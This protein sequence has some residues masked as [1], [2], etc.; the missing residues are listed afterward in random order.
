MLSIYYFNQSI[1]FAKK[2]YKKNIINGRV[3]GDVTLFLKYMILQVQKELGK[4]YVINSIKE[5]LNKSL[6]KEDLQ[7]IKYLL[8]MNGNITTKDLADFY[9]NY[10]SRRKTSIIFKEKIEPLIEKKHNSK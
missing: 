7:I 6:S 3:S 2:Y 9:N 5:N 4:E 10:N 8:T 1:A